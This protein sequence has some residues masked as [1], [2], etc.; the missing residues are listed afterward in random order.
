MGE[1]RKRR[2]KERLRETSVLGSMLEKEGAVRFA[3]VRLEKSRA[4]IQHRISELESR[5]EDRA[6]FGFYPPGGFSL[7]RYTF[8][9]ALATLVISAGASAY[10]VYQEIVADEEKKRIE[11]PVAPPTQE[12]SRRD[13][14]L[15]NTTPSIEA[16]SEIAV[17]GDVLEEE[18]SILTPPLPR[19]S[20]TLEGI[21]N[22]AR[23]MPSRLNEQFAI[24]KRAKQRAARGR[25]EEAL[26]ILGELD[27]Q[28][29]K[30]A[31]GME[32]ME[33][34]AKSL[35]LMGRYTDATDTLETLVRAPVSAG[36]KA[37]FFRLLGDAQVHTGQC[38]PA[39]VSYRRALGLG[40]EEEQAD[41]ARIGIRKC[42]P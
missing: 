29:P 8:V 16:D 38:K 30:G 23:P 28:Y 31:L 1:S 40:L 42:T 20:Q 22:E 11:V 18:S 34:R 37:Q 24:F 6:H 7:R 27:E 14:R 35:Y 13:R 3:R 21:E 19:Y 2:P 32:S 17:E 25:H 36:K 15:K 39:L 5:S 26:K 33:L 9:A 41:A 4:A 10:L 12:A